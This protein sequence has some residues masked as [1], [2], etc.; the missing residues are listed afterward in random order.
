MNKSIP[1]LSKS[2]ISPFP[3]PL[4]PPPQVTKE[5]F[6][7]HSGFHPFGD[8]FERKRDQGHGE[9]YAGYKKK[10]G[11]VPKEKDPRFRYRSGWR[12]EEGDEQVV[13][14]DSEGSTRA[15]SE[16]GDGDEMHPE[17]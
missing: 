3:L 9:G 16:S 10:M 7:D 11:R 17:L 5:Y 8:P 4:L 13:S 2:Q 15:P 6:P 14:S 1:D 12:K